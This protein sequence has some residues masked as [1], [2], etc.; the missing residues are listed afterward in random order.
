MACEVCKKQYVPSSRDNTFDSDGK[1]HVCCTCGKSFS[2]KIQLKRHMQTHEGGNPYICD[3]CEKQ[4]IQS[5]NLRLTKKANYL[6]EQCNLTFTTKRML[7]QHANEH[8]LVDCDECD[9]SFKNVSE[10]KKHS[11]IHKSQRGFIKTEKT[12]SEKPYQC[13]ECHRSFAQ[14][15]ILEKHR[16]SHKKFRCTSCDAQFSSKQ[17]L[18]KHCSTECKSKY[19][20]SS[21]DNDDAKKHVCS[22]CNKT[23]AR[24]SA[25]EG[26][27]VS[28]LIEKTESA[29]EDDS[30]EDADF[31]C[32]YQGVK[33]QPKEMCLPKLK[34]RR[35]FS[36]EEC[37]KVCVSKKL[38]DK[39]MQTHKELNIESPNEEKKKYNCRIC[40]E[41]FL[42]KTDYKKHKLSHIPKP[43]DTSNGIKEIK[44]YMCKICNEVFNKKKHLKKHFKTHVLNTDAKP[45][46]SKLS[47][48]PKKRQK[49]IKDL[50][51]GTCG[52]LFAG[53]I[54]L[55]KHEVKHKVAGVPKV[56]KV[57]APLSVICPFCNEDFTGRRF[58]FMR[59]KLAH[60]PEICG[61]CDARFVDRAA[62]REHL[63]THIGTD[64]ARKFLECSQ[65]AQNVKSNLQNPE[66]KVE[67]IYL[68]LR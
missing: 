61:I 63:K 50:A 42:V 33:I 6:C 54:C 16:F 21:L 67:Y 57:R 23:F 43:L 25:L 10:L 12:D 53:E 1:P 14:L 58:L 22:I 59:H 47:E 46:P 44:T 68:V 5:Y 51:C 2:L 30:D 56:K 32:K 40:N 37:K 20:E 17:S 11:A 66:G 48:N 15:H 52:K 65:K 39:H 49:R 60:T 29:P 19:N 34:I 7:L 41:A 3:A 36:C 62:L 24:K 13:N 38:L 45:N 26:H 8:N 55:R 28:H 64:E 27:M 31:L 18:D 9:E 4:G 35:S